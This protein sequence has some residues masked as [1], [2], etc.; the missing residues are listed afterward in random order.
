MSA[1]LIF[2]RT[3]KV[4]A[5]SGIISVDMYGSKG[6]VSGIEVNVENRTATVT[7]TSDTM[8]YCIGII[9]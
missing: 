1:I 5:A 9:Q 3:N 2:I 6:K 4:D 7:N 8:R